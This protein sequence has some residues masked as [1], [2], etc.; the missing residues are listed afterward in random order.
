MKHR[1]PFVGPTRAAVT[2]DY[3]A[4]ALANAEAQ[5][6][7]LRTGGP[8]ASHRWLKAQV[9]MLFAWERCVLANAYHWAERMYYHATPCKRREQRR[10]LLRAQRCWC[11]KWE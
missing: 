4:V 5:R 9:A 8:I 1:Y 2:R 3:V 7:Y 6:A 11:R 10:E